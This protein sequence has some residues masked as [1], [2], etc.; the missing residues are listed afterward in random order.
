MKAATVY[1]GSPHYSR[2]KEKA[3]L[4]RDLLVEIVDARVRA[5][6]CLFPCC[7]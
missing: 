3:D 4:C 1:L 7:L 5:M 2:E 6:F